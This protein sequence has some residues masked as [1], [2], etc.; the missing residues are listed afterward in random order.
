MKK[1]RTQLTIIMILI[2]IGPLIVSNLIS[3]KIIDNKYDMEIESKHINMADSICKNVEEFLHK[4]YLITEQL[5]NNN[6]IRSFIG[7][8]QTEVIK[9]NIKRN[10]Y[11]ELIYIQDVNGDQ[12]ARTSGNLGNRAS[13]WWF[14]QMMEDKKPFLSKSYISIA[15]GNAVSSVFFPVYEKEE[16]K[17]ILG[18]DVNL[19][20]FQELV[21]K[22]NIGQ[23]SYIYIVD[24]QGQLVAHPDKTLVEEQYNYI[25]LK[26]SDY[27]KDGSGNKLKD[28]NGKFKYKEKD[29]KVSDKLLEITKEALSGKKGFVQYENIEGEQVVSAYTPIKVPGNSKDWAVITV[30]EKK[31]ALYFLN[32]VEKMNF[33]V[34]GIV[35][36]VMIGLSYVLSNSITRPITILSNNFEKASQGDLSVVSNY[37]NNNEIG[38][39]SDSFNKMINNTRGVVTNIK[40]SSQVVDSSSESLITAIKETEIANGEIASAVMEVA[41][42][43]NDQSMDAQKGVEIVFELDKEINL[44]NDHVTESKDSSEKIFEANIKS[45]DSFNTLEDK[46]KKVNNTHYEVV[47][48]VKNLNEKANIIENILETITNISQQTNLLALNAAIEAARAGEVGRGFAVVADEIRNLANDTATSS[49]DVANIVYSIKEEV[50]KAV[51]AIDK[52]EQVMEEQNAALK[53][54]M[55]NF[56]NINNEINIIVDKVEHIN[57]SVI[58]VM[59][60][61]KEVSSVVEHISAVCEETS[62]ST[63]EVSASIEEQN[64]TITEIT[65]MSSAL[66]NTINELEKAIVTFKV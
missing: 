30:Q 31:E 35:A 10:E 12:T 40:D 38:K 37:K 51:E 33:L 47:Q 41:S 34:L 19:K 8:E 7:E 15:N 39:L 60:I 66:K 42:G 9:E 36:L 46:V 24:S 6:D 56:D 27:E 50:N 45:I 25:T 11:F 16:L 13:R 20:T 26:R 22:F 29:I 63:E 48:V 21:E 1:L 3:L 43:A 57:T 55:S 2:A 54:A 53:E 28:S 4:S 44:M 49:S 64:A 17:G 5:A 59:D 65:N 58:K 14:K 62:A 61:K 18:T 23:G 32:G 52:N